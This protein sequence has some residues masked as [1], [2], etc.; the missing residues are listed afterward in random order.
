MAKRLTHRVYRHLDSRRAPV[1]QNDGIVKQTKFDGP[2]VYGITVQAPRLGAEVQG[3]V[4]KSTG[5]VWLYSSP[6]YRAGAGIELVASYAGIENPS[7]T[8]VRCLDGMV[9][10]PIDTTAL[11]EIQKQYG[12]DQRDEMESAIIA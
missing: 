2:S 7:A 11:K 1:E 10:G 9:R 8:A 6:K 5:G 12:P 4:Q 3:L